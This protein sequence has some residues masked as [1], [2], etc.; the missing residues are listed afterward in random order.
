MDKKYALYICSGCS[1]GES[2]NVEK[3][4][5]IA[6]NAL[7]IPIVKSHFA[8]CGK[9]GVDLIKNDI[10]T[11]GVNT[12]ILAACSQ[13]VKFEE[14]D[15]PGCIVERAPIRELAVWTQEAGSP[16]AQLAAEDYTKMA[17]IKAQKGDLPEPYKME[18]V[19]TILVI[20]GG[21][22][23][24]RAALEAA[25][26]GSQVFLVE[27]E[28]QL[29]GFANKLYKKIPTSDYY[30]E[31]LIVD[32]NIEAMIK[33]VET[34]SNIKVF[35]SSKVE[36]TDGMPGAFDVT[37]STGDQTETV[38]IGSI[39]LAAG[40]KPYDAKKLGHLGYGKLKNVVTNIQFEEIAKTGKI[41]RPSD[42]RPAK[43]VAFIQCAGQRDP[44]H[45][46]YCSSMCCA[47]SLK[48]AKYVRQDPDAVAMIL[49]KDIRTPGRL[50]YY[51][52]EAQNDP[53]VM[54]T[55]C[56]VKGLT[57]AAYDNVYIEMKDSLLGDVTVEA[58]L[59]VLATGMVPAT[60]EDPVLNLA[61]RQGPGLPDLDLFNGFADSNFICFQYETRRTGVYAAGAVRQP[62]NMAEAQEDAAGAALK[63]IQSN[64]HSAAGMAVHPRA[65]DITFPDP[66]MTKCTSC[67]RCTE[68]CPFG[69]IDEDEKGTP[70]YK[71]GRCRRCG[72]CMGAC[73]ERIVSFKDFHV[74]MIGT[75][76]KNVSVPDDEDQPRIILL[77]CENDAYPAIDTVALQHG[78]IDPAVRIIQLR[79][80]GAVNLV[81]IADAFSRGIDGIMMLGCKYG[82]NYQCHMAKGSELANYRLSKVKE[83]LDKLQLEAERVGFTQLAIDDYANIPKL[84]TDFVDRVKEIGPNPF[85]GF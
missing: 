34:N 76:M 8:L 15:F 75:M 78:K 25:N 37:I 4:A 58:D 33:E 19:K 13:R 2:V 83:T 17:V 18:T 29:G 28:A 70:F 10:A 64:E 80:M 14:F 51:Y 63:A 56:E 6:K 27:K 55:K 20:G 40:W 61:Y 82:D 11:E 84:I 77:C 1:I 81:W 59:V 39:V 30:K 23:G 79:C 49:Y 32:T 50:E 7:K 68:E 65:W 22:S 46:T 35:K 71:I 24:M 31:P 41:L 73:P 60:L 67:K 38:K 72:T 45:L 26:M 16:Q 5:T 69:A 43:K 74:D 9:E 57:E 54:L 66:F 48:Q 44:N 85:K 53:G 47:T 52:K 62:M 36:K 21:I 42:K 12:L 3:I